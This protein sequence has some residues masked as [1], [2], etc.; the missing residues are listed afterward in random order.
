MFISEGAFIRIN[1]VN[2]I[3][4]DQMLQNMAFGHGLHFFFHNENVCK[5]IME[6][7]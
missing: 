2:S 6:L 7:K 3:V 5:K 4:S 1:I